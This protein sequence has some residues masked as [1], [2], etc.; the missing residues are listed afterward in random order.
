MTEKELHPSRKV[1]PS[2]GMVKQ[3][4]VLMSGLF[5]APVI[6]ASTDLYSSLAISLAF[7]LVTLVSVSIGYFLPRKLVFAVRIALY[8]IIAASVYAPA[9]ILLN[10]IFPL[11]VIQNIGI[12]LPIIITNPLILSKTESRFYFRPFKYMLKDAVG[13]VTG[14]DL[15]CITVGVIRDVLANNRIGTFR[16]WLPFQIPALGTV[17]G[18]FILV[19]VLSGLFRAVYNRNKKSRARRSKEGK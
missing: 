2:D 7:T 11:T 3:N 4:V 15:V 18:G 6:A 13:F 12:Y 9:A 10:E 17:F 1:K 14:F 16:M 8:A 5:A 19:G